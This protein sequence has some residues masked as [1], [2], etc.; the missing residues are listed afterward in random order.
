MTLSSVGFFKLLLAPWMCKALWA[1]L[2]DH[3]GTK[4]LWLLY[5]MIGIVITCV[6]GA[7]ATPDLVM[8]LAV[9]LFMFN[10]LTSTQ[11]IAV[12]GLAI[13]ILATSE[14]A[15]GNIAQVVGYKIGAIFSGGLLTWL[16][17]YLDWGSLFLSLA[18]VYFMAY[19]CVFKVVPGRR[20]AV[21]E[22]TLTD[23]TEKEGSLIQP[24]SHWL[25]EHFKLILDSEETRW[26]I[27]YVLLYKL[28][29]C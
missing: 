2:V 11:D 18:M 3:Y 21:V 28:G 19:V 1:P 7:F 12:D 14:L 23:E 9:V 6:L 5:S 16:S 10:L 4:K 15:N 17:E 25:I 24:K 8:Q 26:T 20:P 22:T 27:V 29:E 13:Q